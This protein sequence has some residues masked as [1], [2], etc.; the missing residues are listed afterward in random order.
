MTKCKKFFV[1]SFLIAAFALVSAQSSFAQL[2][3]PQ[4]VAEGSSGAFTSA[5][6]AMVQADPIRGGGAYCGTHVWTGSSSIASA[7]DARN[8]SIPAEGGTVAIVWDVEPNPTT[9]CVYLSVDSVVGQRLFL[10]QSASG[11]ATISLTSAALS[12]NGG[13]KVSYVKDDVAPLPSDVYTIVN[14]AHFNVAFTDIRP[15]DGQYAYHRA[16]CSLIPGDTSVQCMGYGPEGGIGTAVLSSYDS[17]KANVVAYSINGSDPFTHIPIPA[18]TTQSLGASPIVVFVNTHN[19]G[20]GHFGGSNPTFTNIN[21]QILGNVYT[22]LINFTG[23]INPLAKPNTQIIFPSQ[24]EP[25]S[26]TYNTFEWQLVR[27]RDGNSDNS[28]ETGVDPTMTGCLV[29]TGLYQPPSGGKCGNPLNWP[30]VGNFAYRTRSIGTGQMVKAISSATNP[31]SIGYAFFGLGTFGN[32]ANIKY[33]TLDGVDPIY[34]TYSNG[35]FPNCTGY[36]NAAPAFSC[37]S[38]SAPTFANVVAG[39]YRVW[40]VLRAIYYS[41][42]VVPASGPSVPGLITAAQDSAHASVP[43]FVPYRYCTSSSC[44][45]VS[46]PFTSGLSV[47]RSHYG[48]SGVVNEHNGNTAAGAE[49]GGDMA[50]AIFTTSA[51]QDLYNLTGS[52]E[53]L[54][55]IQ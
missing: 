29:P 40:S 42:Y 18:F 26:G 17:T 16:A 19:N 39:N 5:V 43:D 53:F 41:S 28:Q 14:G 36:F 11:N 23:D 12:T 54:T 4:I 10:G 55:Y 50:G 13:N 27:A 37:P 2:T 25:V 51:D 15:E 8:G 45:P 46:G 44:D 6:I 22:G 32:I 24:R 3:S 9:V 38:G 7:V 31:D 1:A 20:D 52:S 33:L 35:A 48:I 49:A 30:A 21:S 47:F 34:G